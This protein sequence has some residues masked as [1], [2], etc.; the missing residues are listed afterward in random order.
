MYL[1]RNSR[2]R[3]RKTRK[4]KK[5]KLSLSLFFSWSDLTNGIKSRGFTIGQATTY[6]SARPW[7]QTEPE[8]E[9]LFLYSQ[10]IINI[11]KSGYFLLFAQ[12]DRL[13]AL[14]IGAVLTSPVIIHCFFDVVFSFYF[15][16]AKR[17]RAQ[18]PYVISL[19]YSLY[20]WTFDA[21]NTTLSSKAVF[22]ADE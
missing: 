13:W 1:Q 4:M 14:S 19:Y 22:A 5:K 10:R 8:E 11:H 21:T 16:Q 15:R 12:S 17:K 2:M 3:R 9:Y 20:Y 18:G 6:W 7:I